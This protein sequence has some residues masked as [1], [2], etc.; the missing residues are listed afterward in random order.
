MGEWVTYDREKLYEEVWA[1][2]L[3]AV[4]PRYG[5]SDVMLGKVCRELLIPLPGRGYWA[6]V[7]AR[8]T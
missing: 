3:R 4:A 7:R 8:Q 1:E 2:P 5:V 6:K